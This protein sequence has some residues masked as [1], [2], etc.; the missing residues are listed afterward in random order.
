MSITSLPFFVFFALSLALYYLLPKRCQWGV[1]LGCSL[2]FFGLSSPAYTV[3]YLALGVI[4]TALC[5]RGIARARENGSS[6][7]AR[8]ALAVGLAVD[9]GLLAVLKYTGFFLGNVN[10]V[11][12]WTGLWGPL[13]VP[14]LLA[15]LG[16]SFYTLQS[17]GY[18]LDAYWDICPIQPSVWK[19]ALFVGY[20][21]QLTSGPIARYRDMH[22]RLYAPHGFD[23]RRV[24]FGLQRMLWGIFKKLVISARAGVV[25][26]TVFADPAAHPGFLVWIGAALFTLQLYTDFSGCMDIVLGISECY[27]I[28]LPENFR[29]PFFSRS[30]QEFWQRWHITLG[31]APGPLPGSPAGCG[32]T[33][34]KRPPGSCPACWGCCVSGCSSACGTAAA[35]STFWAWACGSGG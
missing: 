21:P 16:I 24:A 28:P 7:R 5:A 35:G 34:A 22:E 19:T 27:G 3:V 15:P 23:S 25:A 2:V 10:R 17:V 33:W 1:L 30:V 32:S 11:G 18:L 31:C 9:L 29:T 26:N 8:A 6:G 12:G 13:P 20:Y 4:A 14:D